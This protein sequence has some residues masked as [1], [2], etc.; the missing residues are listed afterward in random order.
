MFFLPAGAEFGKIIH[1]LLKC[2]L[3][4]CSRV[5]ATLR[6][7]AIDEICARKYGFMVRDNTLLGSRGT[8]C[9]R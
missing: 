2:Y 3:W 5:V 9:S 1:A 6:R 4:T 8:G 7:E